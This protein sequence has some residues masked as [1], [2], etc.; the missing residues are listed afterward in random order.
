MPASA[1]A[2]R[3]AVL[4]IGLFLF[5]GACA[6]AP[7]TPPQSPKIV[8]EETMHDFGHVE[9]GAAVRH[10]FTFRN[11]GGLDLTIANVRASCG[12]V[13][14]VSAAR[15]IPAGASGTIQVTFDTAREV[16]HTVRTITV[17]SNDPVSPVTSLTLRGEI[18]ADVTAEPSQLYLGHVRAGQTV[19]TEVRVVTTHDGTV[20]VGGIEAG[21]PVIEA[22]AADLSRR[23]IRVA[24][25]KDAP[26][27]RFTEQLFVRT[28]SARH[29]LVTIPIAG[30]VDADAL[31]TGS[32]V[33]HN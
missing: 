1:R 26:A 31:S 4:G 23:R 11:G 21:G 15:G 29:P 24:V 6:P 17:D 14:T 5:S 10:Q 16:G 12:C 33:E 32:T 13:A 22:T 25:R 18:D 27:G 28:T 20:N 9:Q 8:F 19:S 7:L 3:R 2:N 30:T